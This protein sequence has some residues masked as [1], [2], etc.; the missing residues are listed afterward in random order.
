MPHISLLSLTHMIGSCRT[1]ERIMSC[2]YMSHVTHM[3]ESCRTNEWLMPRMWMSHVTHMTESCHTH[4]WVM[5]QIWMRDVARMNESCHKVCGCHVTYQWQRP[6]VSHDQ[7]KLPPTIL[8][9]KCVP[10]FI[11]TCLML[12]SYARHSSLTCAP[13]LINVYALVYSYAW[14]ELKLLASWHWDGSFTILADGYF[15][16]APRFIHMSDVTHLYIGTGKTRPRH[17]QVCVCAA[18]I[19]WFDACVY[20]CVCEF[21]NFLHLCV[22]VRVYM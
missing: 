1:Y 20:T 9:L 17:V 11:Y 21:L 10:W 5:P 13:W 8:C 12:Q 18:I 14:F 3:Y 15:N 6:P 2:I 16:S 22:Y 7:Q 19:Q 4:G